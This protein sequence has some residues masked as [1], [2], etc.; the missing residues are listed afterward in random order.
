MK[1]RQQLDW[2]SIDWIYNPAPGSHNIMKVGISTMN[3]GAVQ[4]RHIHVGD[5]QM[6]YVISG[7]GTQKINNKEF[8]L[9]PG[10]VFHISSGMSHETANTDCVPL[11]K[12]L[13]S[14]PCPLCEESYNENKSRSHLPKR[15]YSSQEKHDFLVQSISE[16]SDSMLAPLKMPLSIYDS[17]GNIVYC[18]SEY[19]SFCKKYC[20]IQEAQSNCPLYGCEPRK[21][22]S[23]SSVY[24]CQ[25]GLALYI[26]PIKYEEETLGYIRAGHVRI[27]KSQ[28]K[29]RPEDLPYNVPNSTI[30]GILQVVEKLASVIAN[31]F[32]VTRIKF[33]FR[34]GQETLQNQLVRDQMLTES[35]RDSEMQTANFKINRHFMFNTLNMILSLA[36]KEHAEQTYTAISNFSGM[37]QYTLRNNGYFVPLKDECNYIRNYISLQKMRFN[38]RLNCSFI[39]D[40][41][42]L[43]IEVPSNILQPIVE[44][45]FI[46]G[47]VG[48]ADNMNLHISIK[49]EGD[50][51]CA[52]VI[53]DGNGMTEGELICL[54]K[55]LRDDNANHGSTM[56]TRKLDALYGENYYYG[57]NSDESGTAVTVR[58]PIKCA[59]N[60]T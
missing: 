30:V 10:K 46:H 55:A 19:P 34:L 49:R 29:P 37:L 7:H 35:L 24:I 31:Y 26:F 1:D 59:G 11:V 14:V 27:S 48:K 32:Y 3:V 58:I 44:N 18:N 13:V 20:K 22:D 47:F 60:A 4:P 5:E 54:R 28:V 45:C 40:P 53:D 57:V 42:L 38:E 39:V 21:E 15:E 33:Q 23:S 25:Y 6:I 2:G 17:D 9:E 56:V 16:I 51:I 12:L 43:N 36:I 8:L 41:S 52:N 50:Y